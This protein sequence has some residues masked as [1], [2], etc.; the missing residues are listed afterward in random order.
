MRTSTR[1]A[2]IVRLGRVV[3][4]AAA[5]LLFSAPNAFAQGP[6]NPFGECPSRFKLE[7]IVWARDAATGETVLSG[8]V[9]VICDGTEVYADEIRWNDKTVSGRG[10]LLVVQEGLRVIADRMEIDRAT[11]LGTFWSAYGTARLTDEQPDKNLFGT[12]E[13][14]VMFRAERI[15]RVG[16]RKYLMT[17]GWFTTCLQPEPRWAMTGSSGTITLDDSVSMRNVLF[18]VK[19]VPVLYAPYLYYPLEKEDRKT[20]FLIPTYSNSNIRGAGISAAFFWAI[21]R[22]QDAT[23]YWDGYWQFGQGVAVDYRY[24]ATDR[25]AGNLRVNSFW[26][27]AMVLEDGTF[28]PAKQSWDMRGTVN[29]ALGRRFH[30]IGNVDYFS[31]TVTQQLYQQSARDFTTSSRRINFAVVGSVGKKVRMRLE[32]LYSQ[33]DVFIDLTVARRLGRTPQVRAIFDRQAIKG[34][35]STDIPVYVTGFAEVANL[36]VRPDLNDPTKDQ[37][38]WRLDGRA[39]ISST[40][41]KRAW[42]SVTPSLTW[43]LTNWT[44]SLD[45]ITRVPVTTPLTRSLL[46][47]T[48]NIIGPSFERVWRTP[49]NGYAGWFK[50]LIEPRV[51]MQWMTGFDAIGQVIQVDPGID[52][53]VGGTFASTYSLT[54][55][56]LAGV[57]RA[58]GNTSSRPIA[59]VGIGQTYYTNALAGLSNTNYLQPTAA[60]FQP[61][62]LNAS[63]SPIDRVTGEFQL[64]IHPIAKAVQ[65]YSARGRITG[66][67]VD[68][69]GGWSKVQVI[70]S[71]PGFND[72]SRAAQYLNAITTVKLLGRKATV[73]YGFDWDI[74][75]NL[76]LQQRVIASYI[77]QCC[78]FSVDYQVRGLGHLVTAGAPPVDRRWSFSVTLAGIGSFS[79]PFGSFRQ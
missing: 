3:W 42:M 33:E 78:G 40:V 61:V 27:Q 12:L 49:K 1:N 64:Y 21:N 37:Q 50:H 9:T 14:E 65:S 38:H 72:P 29:Q 48:T 30:L 44:E 28:R 8:S 31:D 75:T 79:N 18:K 2:G 63:V 45:P 60:N 36:D 26:E 53:I 41:V 13:P 6:A 71:V 77:A 70:P 55:T 7:Y 59:S 23:V 22:S 67:Y 24:A 56:I 34:T 58:D 35:A 57:R 20:G 16:P 5:A 76:L 32:G 43:R 4:A 66:D 69:A 39:N 54:N 51:S 10:N 19:G 52:S 17:N 47:F 62:W 46:D 74:H 68:F 15:E 25:D 73:S 11:K